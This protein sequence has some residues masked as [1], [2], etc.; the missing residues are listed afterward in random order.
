MTAMSGMTTF[1][2]LM[3][4]GLVKVF[5]VCWEIRAGKISERDATRMTE[6]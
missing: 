2:V 1:I 4:V 6:R 3:H 5:S